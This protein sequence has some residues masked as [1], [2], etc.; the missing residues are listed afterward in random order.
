MISYPLSIKL[1][2]TKECNL[3]CRHCFIDEYSNYI[4][5][6][7]IFKLVDSFVEN[8]LPA[9]C[10]TGGEPFMHKDIIEILEYVSNK[11]IYLMIATNGTLITEKIVEKLVQLKIDAIQFSVDGYNEKQHDYIRGNGNFKKTVQAI[12][13][14]TKT[15]ITVIVSQVLNKENYQYIEQYVELCNRLD[16]K[17]IR[18]ELFLPLGN[19]PNYELSLDKKDI[20]KIFYKLR[21]LEMKFSDITIM[22]PVFDSEYSCGAGYFNAIIN[23]DLTMSPCD[24]LAEDIYSNPITS[25]NSIEEIWKYDKV[26]SDWRNMTIKIE[27]NDCKKCKNSNICGYG[28]RASALA[29]KNDLQEEDPICMTKYVKR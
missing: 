8:K 6:A 3:R 22:Y 18:F 21:E 23:P 1:N 5:K 19:D 25:E 20:K 4:N 27:N 26:F 14:L 24:L 11:N 17:C 16:V 29:Y 2:I 28:C 10:I 7:K 9:L 13:M 15:N 12:Q